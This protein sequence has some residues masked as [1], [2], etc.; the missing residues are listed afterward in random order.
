MVALLHLLKLYFHFYSILFSLQLHTLLVHAL[1][2]S[3]EEEPEVTVYSASNNT[4]E[5]EVH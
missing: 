1:I 4:N 3:A 5:R 2:Q